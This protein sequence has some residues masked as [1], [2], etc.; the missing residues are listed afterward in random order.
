[1][2]LWRSEDNTGVS[3]LSFPF[4]IEIKYSGYCSGCDSTL[5]KISLGI[6]K[7]LS[8]LHFQL[9]VPSRGRSRQELKQ[10]LE[11]E[12]TEGQCWLPQTHAWLPSAPT[13]LGMVKGP[14]SPPN[15]PVSPTQTALT[16][17]ALGGL[18]RQLMAGCGLTRQAK[19]QGPQVSWALSFA[20]ITGRDAP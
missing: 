4:L 5:T 2:C 3:P 6:E 20:V 14:S 10:D 8:G 16:S 17:P 12:T 9:T 18:S 15:K 11:A 7:A 13:W 1:M 19:T